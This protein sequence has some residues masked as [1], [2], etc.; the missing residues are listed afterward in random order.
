MSAIVNKADNGGFKSVTVTM[1]RKEAY[2][3]A[4]K[5]TVLSVVDSVTAI[6]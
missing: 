4:S 6:K 1:T 5:S 2:N 3:L